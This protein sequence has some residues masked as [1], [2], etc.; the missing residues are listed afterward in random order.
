MAEGAVF[1]GL[2]CDEPQMLDTTFRFDWS[3]LPE[4]K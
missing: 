1:Y 4:A 3:Q 2:S